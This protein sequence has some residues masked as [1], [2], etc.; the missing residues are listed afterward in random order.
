[1][2]HGVPTREEAERYEREKERERAHFAQMKLD[3]QRLDGLKSV[4]T[5][6]HVALTEAMPYVHNDA[7][8]QKMQDVLKRLNLWGAH[9]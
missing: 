4:A 1:M 6:A 8:K 7:V 9:P 2:G 3:A 5:S